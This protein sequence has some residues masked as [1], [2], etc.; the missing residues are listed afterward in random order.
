MVCTCDGFTLLHLGCRCEGKEVDEKEGEEVR[1][2]RPTHTSPNYCD[3]LYII[4]GGDKDSTIIFKDGSIGPTWW[5]LEDMLC[6]V[7]QNIWE[8]I[9]VEEANT[10]QPV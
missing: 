6:A 1:Y 8:E 7:T 5:K 10:L 9:S 2:F 4:Y 3:Q